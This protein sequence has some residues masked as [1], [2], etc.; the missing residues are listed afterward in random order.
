MV[1]TMRRPLPVCFRVSRIHSRRHEVRSPWRLRAL[2]PKRAA[3][4]LTLTQTVPNPPVP[5]YRSIT[6]G[7]VLPLLCLKPTPCRGRARTVIGRTCRSAQRS[8]MPTRRFSQTHRR[9]RRHKLPPHAGTADPASAPEL[10]AAAPPDLLGARRLR[11]AVCLC[12][13][14]AARPTARP[15]A[16][17]PTPPARSPPAPRMRRSCARRAFPPGPSACCSRPLRAPLCPCP[18]AAL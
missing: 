3:P 12:P 8:P 15:T 2:K 5:P 9:L 14:R 7:R 4:C 10:V 6:P 18:R 13:D 16:R 11:R 17:P 1:R